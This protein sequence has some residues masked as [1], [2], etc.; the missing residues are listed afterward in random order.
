MFENYLLTDF[1][2]RMP[3]RCAIL[4]F[5]HEKKQMHDY[6]EISMIVSGN[7]N[8]DLE[9]HLYKLS[10]GDIFCVNP[11]TLHELHGIDCVMVSI[12]FNQTTF[13]RILPLPVNPQFFCISSVTDKNKEAFDVMRS[14]IANFTK[15]NADKLSGY[16]LRNWSYIYSLMDVLYNNFRIKNSDAKE[17]KNYRYAMRIAEISEIIQNNYTENLTLNDLAD[18]MHLS[19]PYLSKFFSEYYGMNFLSCLNQYRLNHAVQELTNTDKNIDEIAADSGFSSSHAFV[20]VFKKNFD[21][22]PN[23]Y[24][25]EQKSKSKEPDVIIEQHDYIA[26]LKKYLTSNQ[27]T[28]VVAPTREK[29]IAL[30][31]EDGNGYP[32]LHTWRNVTT[33]GTASDILI[34]DVQQMLKKVQTDIGFRYIK[35]N[36]VFSDD[37]HVYSESV[38][39]Q[40]VFNFAYLDKVFDFLL[41]CNLMPWIQ[42]SYMPEKLAKHPDRYLFNENVSQPKSN[43]AWCDLIQHFF[44][45]II[46]RYGFDEII[47]WNYSLWNQPNTGSR[48]YGFDNED[49]FFVFYK[50]T[51]RCIKTISA[52]IQFC[53]SPTY[54]LVEDDYQNWYI[55]FLEKCRINSCLPDSISFT[56]YDTKLLSRQ[57]HSK[58]SFG[59]IYTMSLSES[60][61]SMKDFV[62]QVLRERKKLGLGSI[63]IYLTEWNNSPSQQD[64][65]NDT[66]F[67]SCYIVKNILEN[68]DRLQS[69]AYWS[70]TDLMKD[71][72]LPENQFFGGLGLFTTNGLPKASYNAFCLLRKLGNRFLSRGDGYFMTKDAS[73]YQIMLYNYEHFSHLYANGERFDMTETDRYTVFAERTPIKIHIQISNLKDKCYRLTEIYVNQEN[74]S[75]FDAWINA[76]AIEPASADDVSYLATSTHPGRHQQILHADSDG[77]LAFDVTLKLLEVRMLILTPMYAS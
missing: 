71:A 67:K 73:S 35:L 65:L 42:L 31:C 6:F 53:L 7:C 26:G 2:P 74:G 44:N 72:P 58:Q 68:Y 39:G 70:L 38:S 16:E 15:N 33:V 52:D 66:C 59:F 30:S 62:M 76:G 19:V 45:H 24:R 41:S 1:A 48:L 40:A 10:D 32:L 25:R 55:D 46:S 51:Y 61:D 63:P 43:D 57:N 12:L 8:L 20:S 60:P 28:Q 23:Q 69:F 11:H 34:S 18:Q 21:M 75:V 37:F 49:D 14:L 47:K 77:T 29:T 36:G 54:Y 56:Y 22:L 4:R 17:K 27:H 9:G 3:I 5:T 13:E 64:L 50:E